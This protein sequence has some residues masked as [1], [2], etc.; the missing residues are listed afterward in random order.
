MDDA[1]FVCE[2]NP[3]VC[4]GLYTEYEFTLTDIHSFVL[5]SVPRAVVGAPAVEGQCVKRQPRLAVM[6]AN[7]VKGTS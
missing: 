3:H 2:H 1:G 5:Y 4:P 7:A 6:R